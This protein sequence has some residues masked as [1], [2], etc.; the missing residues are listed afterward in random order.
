[1][2]LGTTRRRNADG[3]VV[4]YHQLAENVWDPQ[5]RCAVARVVYNFGRADELDREAL[6][7]A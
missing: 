7:D 3:S 4:E 2:Y 1:M 6:R 5:K